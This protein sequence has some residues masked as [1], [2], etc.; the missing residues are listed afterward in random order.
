MRALTFTVDVGE[1]EVS[2]MSQGADTRE[3]EPVCVFMS[4][5]APMTEVTAAALV[6]IM[7]TVVFCCSGGTLGGNWV[8]KVANCG[9][10]SA[11]NTL[12]RNTQPAEKVDFP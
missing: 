1:Y 5:T 11:P 6:L 8:L 9:L 4:G 7:L 10:T 3:L 12:L 2:A